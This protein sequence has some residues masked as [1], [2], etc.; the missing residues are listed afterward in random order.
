[1]EVMNQRGFS[2]LGV[3]LFFLLFFSGI[4]FAL[5]SVWGLFGAAYPVRTTSWVISDTDYFMY[6]H[7]K[8]WMIGDK[9]VDQEAKTTTYTLT[10][11]CLTLPGQKVT[12]EI[13]YTSHTDSS[14]EYCNEESKIYAQEFSYL[15]SKKDGVK[16]VFRDL[17]KS[18]KTLQGKTYLYNFHD[19]DMTK[20]LSLTVNVP[21]L[22]L[23]DP[24]FERKLDTIVDSIAF[25]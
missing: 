1:M 16:C 9:T 14:F 4:L 23:I 2:V 25:K 11:P 18:G 6:K 19:T 7:P 10:V 5:Y 17:K 20:T 13:V 15:Y 8:D 21:P 3:I 24:T 12:A 22:S